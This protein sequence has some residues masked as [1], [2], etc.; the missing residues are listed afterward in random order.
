MPTR[1]LELSA[2]QIFVSTAVLENALAQLDVSAANH[3][4]DAIRAI[5]AD[6]IVAHVTGDEDD[7]PALVEAC[8]HHT[9]K[10]LWRTRPEHLLPGHQIAA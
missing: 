8:L 6:Y 4:P 2:S 10:A 7:I 3:S 1:F 5:M 9:R